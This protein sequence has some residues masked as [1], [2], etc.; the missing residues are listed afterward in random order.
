MRKEGEG[1]YGLF[2]SPSATEAFLSYRG[3]IP[4]TKEAED[5]SCCFSEVHK[6]GLRCLH[7]AGKPGLPTGLC[8]PS[9]TQP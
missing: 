2:L 9:I 5:V 4:K 7:H 1:A 8:S 6:S 3:G